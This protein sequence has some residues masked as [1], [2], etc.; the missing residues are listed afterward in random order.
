MSKD[1]PLYACS[2]RNQ[3][4][5]SLCQE[6]NLKK[7]E[8]ISAEQVHADGIAIVSQKD[9]GNQIPGVDALITI[10][11]NLPLAVRTA[12]CAPILIFDPK[13]EVLAL[14]HAGRQ[15][16]ELGISSKTIQKIKESF[17]SHPKD[18]FVKIGPSIGKCCYPV[19]LRKENLQ[20][21]LKS[22]INKE[23]IEIHPDCTCCNKHKYFSY[24][25]DGPSTGRM[26]LVAM[27]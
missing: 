10:E 25:G 3:T 17:G 6:L 13:K 22:G 27:L 8:L 2:D 24:R 11:K 7:E 14:V 4:L 19:D 20:Q 5:A 18:L 1:F 16:T 12:D 15:G 21:L 23:N 9:R 26:Y